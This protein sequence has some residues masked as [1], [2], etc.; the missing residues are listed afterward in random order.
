MKPKTH[1]Q[2]VP[3]SSIGS[4]VSNIKASV[5]QDELLSLS[6]DNLKSASLAE[7]LSNFDIQVLM[8]R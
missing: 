6:A 2:I 7:K 8:E 3:S 1:A 5:T 4:L